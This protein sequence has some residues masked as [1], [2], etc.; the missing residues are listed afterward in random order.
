M[1]DDSTHLA[2]DGDHKICFRNSHVIE[3]PI[4]YQHTIRPGIMSKHV[5]AL[6]AAIWVIELQYYD[7]IIAALYQSRDRESDAP[8]RCYKAIIIHQIV[9]VDDVLESKYIAILVGSCRWEIQDDIR[10]KGEPSL[11][12]CVCTDSVLPCLYFVNAALYVIDVLTYRQTDRHPH[13]HTNIVQNKSYGRFGW[14]FLFQICMVK[15]CIVFRHVSNS[16]WFF[17]CRTESK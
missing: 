8:L 14:V 5:L 13:T 11:L 1:D 3:S 2:D 6:V 17:S 7:Q 9:D 10:Y 4:I 12:Y 15:P 16:D